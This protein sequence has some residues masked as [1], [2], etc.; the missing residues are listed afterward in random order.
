MDRWQFLV[1]ILGWDTY[2]T[3]GCPTSIV[4]FIIHGDKWTC[5]YVPYNLAHKQKI[6]AMPIYTG[7]DND[8]W[9]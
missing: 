6:E 8:I 5:E 9:A 7:R 4:N 3:Y 1:D 2:S